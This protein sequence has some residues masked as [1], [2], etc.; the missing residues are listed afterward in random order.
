MPVVA[1]GERELNVEE[2]GRGVLVLA[3]AEDVLGDDVVPVE[4]A[5]AVGDWVLLI[6]R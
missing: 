4:A 1:V 3:P 5:M 6:R 2:L